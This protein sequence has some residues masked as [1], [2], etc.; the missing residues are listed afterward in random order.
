[1]LLWGVIDLIGSWYKNFSSLCHRNRSGFHLSC[2]AC[3]GNSDCVIGNFMRELFR[4]TKG[5][6]GAGRQKAVSNWK[7]FDERLKCRRNN[8]RKLNARGCM[9]PS[10][11]SHFHQPKVRSP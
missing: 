9:V 1:M 4:N 11:I 6:N 8:K 3:Y 5:I 10:A 7:R 2:R